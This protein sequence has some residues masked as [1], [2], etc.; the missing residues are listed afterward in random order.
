MDSKLREQVAE[1]YLRLNGDH[2]MTAEDDAYVNEYFLTVEKLAREQGVDADEIRG[3]MCAG[4]IPLPS[5]LRSDGAQMVPSDL[6]TLAQTADGTEKLAGWF[7]DQF[8]DPAEGHEEWQSYL[9][10]QYV[11]LRHVTPATI[12]RKNELCEEIGQLLESP[13]QES[14]EWLDALH[15]LVDELDA[16]EP[17]FAPYDRLRF[18]GA[19][20]RDELITDVRRRFPAAASSAGS[21]TP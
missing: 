18:G 10:G 14:T 12:K 7:A 4:L 3:L 19:V 15:R 17:P 1:R 11:C 6:L 8:N 5:Y 2:P 21:P 20:S 16:L 13:R 9:S